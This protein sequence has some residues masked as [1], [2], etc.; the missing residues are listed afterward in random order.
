MRERRI[1]VRIFY[2]N[3]YLK[4]KLFFYLNISYI[5]DDAKSKI[6]LDVT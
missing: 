1:N 6:Y 4:V 3:T 5:K 2:L